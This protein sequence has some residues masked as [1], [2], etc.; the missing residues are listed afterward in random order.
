MSAL[1]SKKRSVDLNHLAMRFKRTSSKLE[2]ADSS[3]GLTIASGRFDMCSLLPDE[4]VATVLG[5]LPIRFK[6]Y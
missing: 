1:V 5:F 6:P 4:V 2:A 3:I